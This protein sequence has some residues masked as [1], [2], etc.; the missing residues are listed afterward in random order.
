M[1][2]HSSSLPAVSLCLLL[3]LG[4]LLSCKSSRSFS[5]DPPD[6]R[7][8]SSIQV[9][10]AA[11]ADLLRQQL[12][13]DMLRVENGIAYFY[14]QPGLTERLTA[15]GY[16]VTARIPPETIYTKIV[17]L[18]PPDLKTTLRQGQDGRPPVK[19]LRREKDYL[20]VSASLAVLQQLS[21]SGWKV[22]PQR[23]EVFPRMIRVT[24]R[25]RSEIDFITN[26]IADIVSVTEQKDG[27]FIITGA[28]YDFQLEELDKRQITYTIRES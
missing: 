25:S 13:L 15:L 16:T 21:K 1:K 2:Q 26:N 10:D 7:P 3:V 24:A 6:K 11:E 14:E 4:N 8:L 18:I 22:L 17:R 12:K 27:S 23:G 20:L 9:A 5:L 28:A 19:V